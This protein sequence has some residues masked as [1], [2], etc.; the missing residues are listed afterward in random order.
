MHVNLQ[1]EANGTLANLIRQMSSLST[2]AEN[3]FGELYHE[4]MRLEH[5]TQNLAVRLDRLRANVARLP[6]EQDDAGRSHS[7]TTLMMRMHVD[8]SPAGSLQEALLRKQFR[9]TQ[10]VDQQSLSRHTMPDAMAQQH[11]RL[12][13]PPDLDALNVFRLD[14]FLRIFLTQ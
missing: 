13:T 10:L 9:S 7:L 8:R 14:V 4:A 12:D 11:A 2:H 1:C 6:D 3:I 5:R